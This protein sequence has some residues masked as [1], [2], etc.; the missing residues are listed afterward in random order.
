MQEK[1][2]L[3]IARNVALAQEQVAR[4]PKIASTDDYV[5]IDVEIAFAA[6]IKAH[7]ASNRLLHPS[8]LQIFEAGWLAAVEQMAQFTERLKQK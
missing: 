3:D 2:K 4:L 6:F 8:D 5:S 7:K 1:A